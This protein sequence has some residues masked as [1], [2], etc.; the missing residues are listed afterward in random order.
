[1]QGSWIHVN[2]ATS[3]TRSATLSVTLD[4]NYGD[5]NRTGYLAINDALV[6]VD[7]AADQWPATF[8]VEHPPFDISADQESHDEQVYAG[9][10]CGWDAWSNNSWI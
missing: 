1:V 6:V 4:R 5:G 3:G 9:N 7:Q 8:G 2:G 10:G